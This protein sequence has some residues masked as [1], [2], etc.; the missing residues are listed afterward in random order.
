M[1]LFALFMRRL[2]WHWALCV[3]HMA[4]PLSGQAQAVPADV[5]RASIE[6]E[7]KAI[8]TRWVDAQQTCKQRFAVNACIDEAKAERRQALAVQREAQLKLDDA[9]RKQRAKTKQAAL[10]QKQADAASRVAPVVTNKASAPRATSKPTP[11]ARPAVNAASASRAASA[12][13]ASASAVLGTVSKGA[14]ARLDG[15]ASAAAQRAARIQAQEV[16]AAAQRERQAQ[17]EVKLQAQRASN[18]QK[19]APL[20]LPLPPQ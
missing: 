2:T 1:T 14:T 12:T 8:E 3:G 5:S 11:V 6:A 20:P 16:A 13:P 7:R 10:A 17:R 9:E 19:S 18:P 4:L 15:S